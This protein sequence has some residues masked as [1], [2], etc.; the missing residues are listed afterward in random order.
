[1]KISK[2]ALFRPCYPNSQLAQPK[3]AVLP[4][5]HLNQ[6]SRP[7][8]TLG[9]SAHFFLF[10]HYTFFLSSR[11]SLLAT[12]VDAELCTDQRSRNVSSQTTKKTSFPTFQTIHPSLNRSTVNLRHRKYT[13]AHCQRHSLSSFSL[14]SSPLSLQPCHLSRL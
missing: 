10:E 7:R 1:M 5:R 14:Q 11:T 8:H 6:A 12:V 3:R 2:E 9:P 4:T 13:R